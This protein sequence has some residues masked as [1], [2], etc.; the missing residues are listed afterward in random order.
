MRTNLTA[1]LAA[2]GVLLLA[3]LALRAQRDKGDWKALLEKRTF[4]DG[5]AEL[6]YRLMKPEG[7]D[8]KKSYPLVV[9]LHGAG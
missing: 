8:P 9:F 1:M 6:S 5:K 2:A 7:Y 3:G 4:K